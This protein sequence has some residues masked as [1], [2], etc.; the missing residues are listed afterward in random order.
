MND[1]ISC[2]YSLSFLSSRNRMKAS[3]TESSSSSVSS[4][5]SATPR[6]PPSPSLVFFLLK[7]S[8]RFQECSPLNRHVVSYLLSYRSSLSLPLLHQVSPSPLLCWPTYHVCS[9]IFLSF[10]LKMPRLPRNRYLCQVS[11][12]R[13]MPAVEN[14]SRN[15]STLSEGR[16]SSCCLI[17]V[18]P[19]AT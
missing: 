1:T 12:A 15:P 16:R 18:P 9:K 2:V 13:A 17:A 5:K 8:L 14:I 3:T 19:N 4:H 6:P 7:S 11:T 10:V